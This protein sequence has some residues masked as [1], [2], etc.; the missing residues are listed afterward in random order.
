MHILSHSYACVILNG[1]ARCC[2]A[3]V[4]AA[5]ARASLYAVTLHRVCQILVPKETVIPSFQRTTLAF[6]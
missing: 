3:S 1:R 5:A 4:D 6:I 2:V